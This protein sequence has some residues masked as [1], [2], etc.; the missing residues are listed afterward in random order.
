MIMLNLKSRMS[1]ILSEL[2]TKRNVDTSEKK[3]TPKPYQY[4][5][6]IYN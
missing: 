4:T 6:C 3:P 2:K 5:Y 1:D